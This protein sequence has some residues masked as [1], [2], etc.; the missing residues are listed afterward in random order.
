MVDFHRCIIITLLYTTSTHTH[1]LSSLFT[2]LFFSSQTSNIS[3]LL[4]CCSTGFLTDCPAKNV[5]SALQ[6]KPSN[7]PHH[8]KLPVEIC[9][10]CFTVCVTHFLRLYSLA[11]RS[12]MNRAFFLLSQVVLQCCIKATLKKKEKLIARVYLFLHLFQ[13]STNTFLTGKKKKK[14]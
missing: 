2:S 5:C 4:F 6:P 14:C 1:S 9:C 3:I 12:A 10:P 13:T 11:V 7:R 8:P